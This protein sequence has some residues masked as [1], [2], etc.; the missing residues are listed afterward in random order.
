MPSICLENNPLVAIEWM[1]FGKPIIASNIGWY[2]DLIEN[3]KSWYLFKA[4]D[5]I[6]LSEKIMFLYNKK[7][8]SIEMWRNWFNKIKN[9]FWKDQFYQNL[10]KIYKTNKLIF[11]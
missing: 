1:K 9:D 5:H 3:N 7:G 10:I 8:K 2:P 4:W 11:F 6:D